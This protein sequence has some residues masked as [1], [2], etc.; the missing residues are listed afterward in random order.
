MATLPEATVT[1]DESAGAFAAGTGYL[2]VAAC[3][4]QSADFVPRV[5]A[6]TQDL[7]D[8]YLYNQG[9]DYCSIHFAK[10]RKPVIFVGMP[11]ATPGVVG[12]L[13]NSGV[14][15]SS[16][17]T[18]AAGGSGTMD[19]MNV[20]VTIVAGGTIGTDQITFDLSLDGGNST[21]RVRLGTNSSYTIPFV[22]L[23]VNFGGGSVNTG[24]VATCF[25]TA[26]MWG[27]T[28]MS[29]LR[30]AL[31]GQQNLARS[32]LV[33]GEVPNST[34]AGY[35]VTEANN[36]ETENERFVYARSQVP[37]RLP[38]A[39][40]ATQHVSMTGA[41]SL[42]FVSSG[43]TIT[44]ASGS[45]ITDGFAV[46]QMVTIT[47]TA[48]NNVTEHITAVSSSVL[49]VGAGLANEGPT[50]AVVTVVG[51]EALTFAAGGETITRAG[52]GGN[53]L[54]DG[55]AV[56]DSVTITGTTSNNVTETIT[57]LTSTVMTF[58]T[59][60]ANEGPISAAPV[61]ITKGQT[62][63]AWM[64][65]ETAAFATIDAQPRVDLS[66]GRA[67][68]QSPITGFTM[69][70]PASWAASIREYGHDVQI[71]TYR[72]ADG[73]LDGFVLTDA[74]GNTVEFDERYDGGGLAGRFT[75]LRSYANGPL[76]A[77]V[78]LSLTRDS[79]GKLLSRTHNMAVACLAQTVVQA[80]T[81]NAIGQVL[82]LNGDG[83][84]T[85]ASLSLIEQR[86]NTALQV[87]LLQ[88]FKEGPRASS[89]VWTA[90]RSDVLSTSGST[91]HGTLALNLN[92]TIENIDTTVNVS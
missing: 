56:G 43:E 10:T 71:P 91:L 17:I 7:I 72:K 12:R 66:I 63:A 19:E 3:V 5:F 88:Q 77:F 51:T 18:F 59:G 11:I 70:R 25:T 75:C 85:D 24:D 41:P 4:A 33:V 57:S 87:N 82:V 55:F 15:G 64:S 52:M 60:L 65:T 32:W 81:E 23:V 44:R 67:R 13:N 74:D 16:A 30:A 89:A 37:D 2:V 92:G 1:I 46:G 9:I 21:Q 31:A 14:T 47:G 27:S 38:L 73:P 61:S 62:I 79:E 39:T 90:S 76:G 69:R 84:G 49:T 78:A 36:Y 54:N 34:F 42:T 20:S 26:P 48:S 86:V 35:V 53:W 58:A 40:M 28:A 22:G 6:S 8:Q 50:T 45:W 68:V 29:S 83:T 80:E